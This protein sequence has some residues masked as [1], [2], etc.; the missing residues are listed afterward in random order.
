MDTLT[1]VSIELDSRLS[2][3]IRESN[4]AAF[5]KL[6]RKY[7]PS[8]CDFAYRIVKAHDAPKDIVQE[9]FTQIWINRE[10]W[11]PQVSVR[12]YLFRAVRNA[13]L[14]HLKHLRVTDNW[15]N[16]QYSSV[17]SNLS[18]DFDNKELLDRT[19]QAIE[20]LP[21]RCKTIFLLSREEGLTYEEIASTLN[22]SVKTVKT[23]MGRAFKVLRRLL[24]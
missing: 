17:T 15:S 8:L 24:S 1:P 7:Y 22:I 11:L 2:E 21:E 13:S 14:N 19:L 23:Q 10:N 6:F 5:E 4:V 9:V 3:E 16:E 18:E 12:A 20:L